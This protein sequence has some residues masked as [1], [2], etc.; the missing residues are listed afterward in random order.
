MSRLIFSPLAE[1]D[2]DEILEYIALDSPRTALRFIAKIREKCEMLARN[3]A[4]GRA[5]PEFK[6]GLYR[7]FPNRQLHHF[8]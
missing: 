5:R 1:S 4:M 2:L 7:S 3:P 8:L 6:T